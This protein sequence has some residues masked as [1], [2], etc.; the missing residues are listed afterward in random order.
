M[1]WR[2]NVHKYEMVQLTKILHITSKTF[3]GLIGI[4]DNYINKFWRVFTYSFSKA[5][6]FLL[7]LKI[8]TAMK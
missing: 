5:R 3:I 2:N 7:Q 8:F 6:P 1:L 4:G